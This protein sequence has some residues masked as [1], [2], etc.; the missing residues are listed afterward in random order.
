MR[1]RKVN[2]IDYSKVLE[3]SRKRVKVQLTLKF[4]K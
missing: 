3:L 2:V 4:D 1:V